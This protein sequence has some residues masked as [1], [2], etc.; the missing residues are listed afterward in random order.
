M[1]RSKADRGLIYHLYHLAA[2]RLR[3]TFDAFNR[4]AKAKNGDARRKAENEAKRHA[5]AFCSLLSWIDEKP[6]SKLRAVAKAMDGKLRLQR[7]RYNDP[8]EAAYRDAI[9]SQYGGRFGVVPTP[10]GSISLQPISVKAFK[11]AYKN[12]PEPKAKLQS[13]S[14]IRRTLERRGHDVSGKPGR[15]KKSPGLPTE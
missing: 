10:D 8:I 13:D 12:L 2:L 15:P 11:E 5:S 9:R 14:S 4:A 3:R 7:V 6:S 1:R